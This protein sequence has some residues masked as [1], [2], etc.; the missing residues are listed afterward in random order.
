MTER[1]RGEVKAE[2]VHK[3]RRV[4]VR[5]EG[6]LEVRKRAREEEEKSERRKEVE[7]GPVYNSRRTLLRGEETREELGEGDEKGVGG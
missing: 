6:R 5:R 4:T 2:G 3:C 7:R 1:V